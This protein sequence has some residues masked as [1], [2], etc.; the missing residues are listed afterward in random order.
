MKKYFFISIVFTL[1]LFPAAVLFAGDDQ[2]VEFGMKAGVNGFWGSGSDI[3]GSDGSYL[4]VGFT[5][6]GF[7]DY[8]PVKYFDIEFDI[9]FTWFNYGIKV[10]NPLYDKIKLR[11]GTME[12]PMLFK[13]RLPAGNGAFYAGAGPD[14][15]IVLGNG[16]VITGDARRSFQVDQ[17]FHIGLTASLGYEWYIPGGTNA[18]VEARYVRGFDSPLDDNPIYPNRI[19]ILVGWSADL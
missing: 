11:Y 3:D 5:G 16:Q 2:V 18:Y 6:G 4:S 7:A 9:M 17:V 14:F 1:I 8:V 15:I 19:D 13:G 10:S 12:L